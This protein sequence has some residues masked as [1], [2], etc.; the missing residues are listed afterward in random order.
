M[1]GNRI[2]PQK[3]F[4]KLIL[5]DFSKRRKFPG[6]SYPL[7][8]EVFGIRDVGPKFQPRKMPLVGMGGDLNSAAGITLSLYPVIQEIP[9]ENATVRVGVYTYYAQCDM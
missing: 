6:Y 3:N 4:T 7:Q 9:H 8:K 1:Y 2:V 5:G